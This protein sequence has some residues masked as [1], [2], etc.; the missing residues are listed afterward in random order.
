[1]NSKYLPENREKK[2]PHSFIYIGGYHLLNQFNLQIMNSE[3]LAELNYRP[4]RMQF[5]GAQ[6]PKQAID[7]FF[8]S[9]TLQECREILWD[10]YAKCVLCYDS[11]GTHHDDAA[12]KVHFYEYAEMLIEAAWLINNKNLK[13]R[14]DKLKKEQ[15]HKL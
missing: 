1:M 12:R 11:E 3:E 8:D 7:Y 10:L 9:F 2:N 14:K 13:K 5:V 4:S 6:N 15:N